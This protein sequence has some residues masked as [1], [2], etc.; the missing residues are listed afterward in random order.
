MRHASYYDII[1]A[2]NKCN[3]DAARTRLVLSRGHRQG[4]RKGL[5]LGGICRSG[6]RNQAARQHLG[7]T[8]AYPRPYRPARRRQRQALNANP[9]AVARFGR[10]VGPPLH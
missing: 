1:D 5:V 6:D 8:I 3:F 9:I 10:Q 2:G 7:G 4:L